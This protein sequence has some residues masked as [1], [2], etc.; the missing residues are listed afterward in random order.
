[1][2]E[3]NKKFLSSQPQLREFRVLDYDNIYSQYEHKSHSHE[4]LYVLDG[5]MTLHLAGNLKFQAMPGDFLL[6]PQNVLHRDEFARMKGLRIMMLQFIWEEEEY[7]RIVNNLSLHNLSY[8]VRTECRRRLEFMRAH[9][10]NTTEDKL[11]G[12]IQLHGILMLFYFD[13]LNV[14][15]T[16]V[17]AAGVPMKEAMRRAKH[18]LDDN[19]MDQV[20]L[21]Q[22]AQH[23][24]ISPAYLSRVFH[25]EYGV[26]FTQYLT[27]IRLAAAKELL[28]ST[29]LQIAEVAARCGF[30]SSSYFIKVFSDHY[31]TTPKNYAVEK[32]KS[33]ELPRSR[34]P[35]RNK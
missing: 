10:H 35:L 6:V 22:T 2:Q 21:K 33:D 25:H 23:I 3:E 8:E 12:S 18:F 15:D 1:M 17:P 24:G 20:S 4:L 29:H 16:P 32:G 7:F 26:S 13:L 27:A 9:W 5:R 14:S 28:Q 34:T 19:F 11:H 30:A 31:G